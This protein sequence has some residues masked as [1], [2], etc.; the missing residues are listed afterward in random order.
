M[1]IGNPISELKQTELWNYLYRIDPVYAERAE[2]FVDRIAPV[3]ATIVDYFPYYT[4]H[5][6]HHGY[7]VAKRIGQI[8]DPQCLVPES[9]LALSAQEA[10]LLIAAAYA[11][12]L[13]MTVFPGEE[14]NLRQQLGLRDTQSGS[15]YLC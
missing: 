14:D 11:H 2:T 13:G 7:Q 10:Y 8:L 5:D 6:A 4:R 9:P 3:L 15:P 12:N 1:S